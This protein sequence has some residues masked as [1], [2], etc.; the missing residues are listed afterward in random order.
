MVSE[1]ISDQESLQSSL[2]IGEKRLRVAVLTNSPRRETED[3]AHACY[4]DLTAQLGNSI[5]GLFF[6][7]NLALGTREDFSSFFLF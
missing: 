4:G 3:P 2:D 7:Q 6:C 5:S 1:T